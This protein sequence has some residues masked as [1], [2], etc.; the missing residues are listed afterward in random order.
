MN[1]SVSA[2]DQATSSI[3]QARRTR[4]DRG[5]RRAEVVGHRLEQGAAQLVARGEG[6]RPPGL[7][8]Q[9]A[10]FEHRRKLI[11]KGVE[12]EDVLGGDARPVERQHEIGVQLLDGLGV[13]LDW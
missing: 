1:S 3:C 12:H 11:G 7:D 2:A 13:A 10:V 5:E 8:T 6:L 4:L 9:P